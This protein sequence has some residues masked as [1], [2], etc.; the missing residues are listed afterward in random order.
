[1]SSL[2]TI[3]FDTT[4]LLSRARKIAESIAKTALL[5]KAVMRWAGASLRPIGLRGLGKNR[6]R[7]RRDVGD[8]DY[9][10][11]GTVLVLAD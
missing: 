3:A 4:S 2:R 11:V 7:G 9:D 5:E 10:T 6:K 8:V 1:V